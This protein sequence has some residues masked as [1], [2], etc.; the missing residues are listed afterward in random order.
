MNRLRGQLFPLSPPPPTRPDMASPL[1]PPAG[2]RG[3]RAARTASY[4]L[5]H[6]RCIQTATHPA[7]G[8]GHCHL[9]REARGECAQQPPHRHVVAPGALALAGA[10]HRGVPDHQQHAPDLWGAGCGCTQGW[11][12]SSAAAA[13]CTSWLAGSLAVWQYQLWQ[14]SATSQTRQQHYTNSSSSSSKLTRWKRARTAAGSGRSSSASSHRRPNTC[15]AGISRP[16]R[17]RA[18]D[19]L[20]G[21]QNTWMRS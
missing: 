16:L 15:S 8:D 14:A 17:K 11:R 18:P 3:A 10:V 5:P 19:V 1:P 4:P 12:P 20:C 6:T 7:R 21:C 2:S 9:Q 13:W